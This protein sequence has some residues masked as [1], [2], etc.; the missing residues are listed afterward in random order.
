MTHKRRVPLLSKEQRSE[1]EDTAKYYASPRF[2]PNLSLALAITTALNE[3][4]E[5]RRL[6]RSRVT[7]AKKRSLN[8]TRK[9]KGSSS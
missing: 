4:A 3:I 5:H 1:L 7:R 2:A 8:P 9:G 6:N